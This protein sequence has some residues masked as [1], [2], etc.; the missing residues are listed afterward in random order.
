MI[1]RT[2]VKAGG[3][4]VDEVK[5]N[6]NQTQVRA[7]HTTSLATTG[8]KVKTNVKAGSWSW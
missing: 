2:S 8:L 1:V 7:E 5:L 4:K 3:I 6:H